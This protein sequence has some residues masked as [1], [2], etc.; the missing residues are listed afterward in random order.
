MPDEGQ[1]C[2]KNYWRNTMLFERVR[3]TRAVHIHVWHILYAHRSKGV[4]VLV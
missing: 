4:L 1:K 2:L 3:L